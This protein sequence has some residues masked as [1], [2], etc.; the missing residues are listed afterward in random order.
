M[1]RLLLLLF[2]RRVVVVVEPEFRLGMLLLEMS[3][4]L[5]PTEL[6]PFRPIHYS[7]K[8]HWRLQADCWKVKACIS[9]SGRRDL[10]IHRIVL[11]LLRYLP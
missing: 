3:L 11:S 5:F 8:V 7:S 10:R 4:M 1:V 6:P 9:L 2:E